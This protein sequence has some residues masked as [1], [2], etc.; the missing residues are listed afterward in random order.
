MEALNRD[1][2][3]E[4][5]QK[6]EKIESMEKELSNSLDQQKFL[7][8]EINLSNQREVKL[9]QQ[10]FNLKRELRIERHEHSKLP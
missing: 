10:I 9:K 6:D 5:R 4:N 2:I 1:L 7:E 8:E 3:E